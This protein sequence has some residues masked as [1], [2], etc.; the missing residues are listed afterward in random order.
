MKKIKNGGGDPKKSKRAKDMPM[1]SYDLPTFE[2]SVDARTGKTTSK[3]NKKEMRAYRRNMDEVSINSPGPRG[4]FS[5]QIG[6]LANKQLSDIRGRKA[7][8]R[9]M[10]PLEVNIALSRNKSYSIPGQDIDSDGKSMYDMETG[11]RKGDLIYGRHLKRDKDKNIEDYDY[12]LKPGKKEGTW[13][14]KGI[15]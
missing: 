13:K 12:E 3:V 14:T 7:M 1:P 9:E 2:I 10:K 6:D 15:K 11:P 5:K 8:N 4:K